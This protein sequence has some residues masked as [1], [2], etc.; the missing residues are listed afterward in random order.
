MDITRV[1]S[2][3]LSK[4]DKDVVRHFQDNYVINEFKYY[5]NLRVPDNDIVKYF[6]KAQIT[7]ANPV[8]GQIFLI[9]RNVKVKRDGRDVYETVGTVVFHY[10]FIELRAQQSGEYDGVEVE[11]GPDDYFDPIKVDSR[12]MLRS[13]ATVIRKGKKFVFTAWWDEYVQTTQYGVNA[14]WKSKPHLMLEKCA[15]AGA[16][17]AAFPEWLAGAYSQEEMGAIEKDDDSI[18]AE[19][20]QKEESEK[21]EIIVERVEQAKENAENMEDIQKEIVEI[22]GFMTVLTA[23]MKDLQEKGRF[24]FEKLGVRSFS[25]LE[26]CLLSELK[27][28]TQSLNELDKERKK[29]AKTERPSFTLEVEE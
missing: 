20:E 15:K 28:K 19:F 11:T 17:R 4:D 29:R 1:P 8:L 25:D 10:A 23:D 14:Q 21:R 7:G 9:P 18:V 26:K 16:L 3:L 22:K 12:K 13:R 27:A 24:M 5:K 6:H 2:L